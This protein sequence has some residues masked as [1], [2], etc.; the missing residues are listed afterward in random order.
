[1]V[2]KNKLELGEIMQ[3][4]TPHLSSKNAEVLYVKSLEQATK[5]NYLGTEH[6]PRSTLSAAAC[7]S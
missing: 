1:M 3:P 5:L 6:V 2:N 7:M 4:Q